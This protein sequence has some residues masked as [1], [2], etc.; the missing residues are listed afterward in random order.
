MKRIND[1]PNYY[2]SKGG[3]VCRYY[4]HRFNRLKPQTVSG[5]HRV[6][7]YYNGLGSPH[8]VHRLMAK[9]YLGC[10][11][12]KQVDHIDGNKTN[13]NIKNLRIC[14]PRENM[15]YQNKT[16]GNNPTGYSNI[17]PTKYNSFQVKFRVEGKCKHYGCFKTLEGALERK[18]EVLLLINH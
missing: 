6:I 11:T 18:E 4:N 2:I 8:L 15:S 3:C 9:T 17:Y 12:D 7:L 14:T 5:Y 13:N 16:S 10:I 1:F